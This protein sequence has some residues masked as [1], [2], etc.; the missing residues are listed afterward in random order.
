MEVARFLVRNDA[1]AT[2]QAKDGSTLLNW[3]SSNVDVE[4]VRF[5]GVVD[6]GADVTAHDEEGCTARLQRR[7]R[8]IWKSRGSFSSKAEIRKPQ[9]RKGGRLCIWHRR[10][11]VEIVR[12]LV[13]YGADTRAQSNG[14]SSLDSASCNAIPC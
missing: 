9:T 4:V 11:Y 8:I 6:H 12:F 5:L 2:A 7:S 13:G 14:W 3:A 10:V 1:G